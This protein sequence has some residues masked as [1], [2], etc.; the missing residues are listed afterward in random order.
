MITQSL[1]IDDTRIWNTTHFGVHG[2]AMLRDHGALIAIQR[3]ARLMKRLFRMSQLVVQF[4]HAS[5]EYSA[6]IARDQRSAN[7]W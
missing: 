5:F 2:F 4:R 3:D 6:E 1:F 7:S